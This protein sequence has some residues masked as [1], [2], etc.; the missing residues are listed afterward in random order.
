MHQKFVETTTRQYEGSWSQ[1]HGGE[2]AL[3]LACAMQESWIQW[4]GH[5][6]VGGLTNPLSYEVQIQGFELAHPNIYPTYELLERMKGQVL[7]NQSC[8]MSMTQSKN[9]LSQR[10]VLMRSQY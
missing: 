4:H 6:R 10:G 2:L 1:R 5:R 9:R 3:P 7:Q 8:R